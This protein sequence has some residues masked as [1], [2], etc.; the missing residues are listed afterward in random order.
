MTRKRGLAGGAHL[1]SESVR[2]GL[3]GA[4]S[5]SQYRVIDVEVARVA[6]NPEN[7]VSRMETGIPELASSIRQQGLI[8]PLTVCT[9]Q[10]YVAANPKYAETFDASTEHVVLDGDRRRTAALESGQEKVPVIIRDDLA[11]DPD[12]VR[13]AT[14]LQRLPLTPVQEGRAYQRKVE[15]GMTHAAI[16]AAAGVS[17]SQVTKRLSLLKLPKSV[18][19][20]IEAGVYPVIDGL[21]LLKAD[22][23]VVQRVGEMVASAIESDELFL[24]IDGDADQD[25]AGNDSPRVVRRDL[26]LPWLTRTAG[27]LL[28]QEAAEVEAERVARELGVGRVDAEKAF[29]RPYEHRVYD[30]A[31]VKALAAEGDLVVD[32][33]PYA[34]RQVAFYR[35]GAKKSSGRT[36]REQEAERSKEVRAAAKARAPFVEEL[37]G[38]KPSVAQLRTALV[39]VAYEGVDSTARKPAMKRWA[40]LHPD[41]EPLPYYQFDEVPEA[42]QVQVAWWTY[43]YAMEGALRNRHSP[44]GLQVVR[45]LQELIAIGYRPTESE[46]NAVKKFK[47]QAEKGDQ[48]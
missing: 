26:S 20:A 1:A 8:Q 13:L 39:A 21:N 16:A 3:V 14:A 38:K 2:I 31:E 33:D 25:D 29:A 24:S 12:G 30:E 11:G 9:L 46:A 5:Q 19:V 4:L 47:Q 23:A 36:Q 22:D 48:S 17:Q 34:R 6:A 40:E 27:D 37:M 41:Q 44:P 45:Y 18:Q 7:P 10:A 28:D 43:I 15:K 32:A 35:L 42:D